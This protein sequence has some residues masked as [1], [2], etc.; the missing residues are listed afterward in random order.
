M[1]R[2]VQTFCA[3]AFATIAAAGSASAQVT[4]PV[5]FK[6]A[7]PFIAGSTL[8]PAGAYRI[9][10]IDD[11]SHLLRIASD[12]PGKAS[13]FVE[14]EDA[15]ATSPEGAKKTEVVFKRYGNQYVLKTV[16][17]EGES[18]GATITTTRAE[19]R[20]AKGATP[21][22]LRVPAGKGKSSPVGTK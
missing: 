14:V 6:A 5:E 7:F 13:A 12:K 17:V 10:A 11:D 15:A 16:W 4:D 21:T 8:L 20:H 19:R 1:N 2:A 18:T 22:D 9:E 3:V